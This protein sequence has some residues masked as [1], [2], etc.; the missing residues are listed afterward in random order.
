MDVLRFAGQVEVRGD[1]A[2]KRAFEAR[3]ATAATR[4]A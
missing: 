1:A 4:M 3:V 2:L